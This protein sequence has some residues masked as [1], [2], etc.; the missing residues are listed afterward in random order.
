MS[1]IYER[2]RMNDLVQSYEFEGSVEVNIFTDPDSDD[3]TKDNWHMFQVGIVRNDRNFIES[4][5][6]GFLADWRNAVDDYEMENIEEMPAHL[7]RYMLKAEELYGAPE[8]EV[9]VSVPVVA[10]ELGHD[11]SE[12]ELEE[13][14]QG[15]VDTYGAWV[16]G[17]VFII[18]IVGADVG[19]FDTI[20]GVYIDYLDVDAVKNYVEDTFDVKLGDVVSQ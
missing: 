2:F 13:Y 6:H 14:A 4:D 9:V 20:G 7:R 12:A 18:E 17:E 19:D 16:E 3:P 11:P 1:T 10:E 5:H 8:F 15:A